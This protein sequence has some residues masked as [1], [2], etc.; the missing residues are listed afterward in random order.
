MWYDV[1]VTV[2]AVGMVVCW[3]LGVRDGMRIMHNRE[4]EKIR[5]PEKLVGKSAEKRQEQDA[6][7]DEALQEQMKAIDKYDGWKV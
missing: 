1:V 3:R 5:L 7:V 4:L 2:L 6:P